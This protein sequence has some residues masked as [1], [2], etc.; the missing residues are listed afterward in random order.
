MFYTQAELFRG[1]K[2]VIIGY[3]KKGRPK[4][5]AQPLDPGLYKAS[6]DF[7]HPKPPPPTPKPAQGSNATIAS[8]GDTVRRPETSM[9]RGK[10]TLASLRN[11]L[12][13]KT[14][15]QLG[16]STTGSGLNLGM[17]RKVG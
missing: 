1:S 11:K 15:E 2:E 4:Y 10:T 9:K 12:K 14:N 17:M 6:M 5:G 7:Y 16:L 8:V 13:V 3:D